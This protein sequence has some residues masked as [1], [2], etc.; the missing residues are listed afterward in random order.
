VAANGDGG[1]T[2]GGATLVFEGVMV[3]DAAGPFQRV[4]QVVRSGD[5]RT[6]V[7][8][9]THTNSGVSIVYIESGMLDT[10]LEQYRETAAQARGG[11]RIAG[12]GDV[13]G[14]G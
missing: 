8:E 11:L 10:L 4:M 1:G 12:P 13:P 5:G 2:V 3:P 6:F 7:R 9:M 14:L